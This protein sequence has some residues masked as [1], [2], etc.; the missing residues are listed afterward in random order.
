MGLVLSQAASKLGETSQKRGCLNGSLTAP[1][2][3]H[4][5]SSQVQEQR[6][7]CSGMGRRRLKVPMR[8]QHGTVKV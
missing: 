5:Q 4:Q 8:K 1:G 6:K 7:G 3:F 2:I